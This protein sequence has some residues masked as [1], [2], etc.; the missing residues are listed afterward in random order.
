MSIKVLPSME[1]TFTI[2][3]QGS[4][5]GQMFEGTFTYKR[6]NRRIKSEISKTVARLNED[7]KNLDEDTKFIH[8]LLS[9]L[10]HTLIKIPDW[11]A[12]T[13]FGYE[14]Y[15]DNVIIAVYEACSNFE[16]KWFKEVW[17]DQKEETKKKEE[18]KE[19]K[20]K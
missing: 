10:K 18:S 3:L 19:L 15:D 9:A 6:P 16:D 1:H 8:R 14:L 12:K 5:T 7:L 11:W 17:E 4:E 20:D 13:D 2:K